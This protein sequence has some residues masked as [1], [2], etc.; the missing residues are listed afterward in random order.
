MNK[1]LNFRAAL[2]GRTSYSIASLHIAQEL[3]LLG[4]DI[5]L[6][7]IGHTSTQKQFVEWISERLY[8]KAYPNPKSPSFVVWHEHSL[9]EHMSRPFYA[10]T[11]FEV[12][13]FHEQTLNSLQFPD[14]ILVCSLWAKEVMRQNHIHKPVTVIPLGVD[15]SIFCPRPKPKNNTYVFLNIGKW[16]VRK[17]HDILPDIFNK[18]FIDKDDVELWMC[19]SSFHYSAKEVKSWKKLYLDSPLGHKIRFFDEQPTQRE[20]ADLIANSDCGIYPTKAEGF[21]LP[22]LETMAMNKPV[23][24]TNYSGQTEFCTEKNSYLVS[25]S[26]MEPA[27]DNKWFFGQGSWAHLSNKVDDFVDYMRLCYRDRP[28]NKEGVIT[29]K[30]FSWQNS[31]EL[32]FK[33]IYGGR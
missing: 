11:I 15:N 27:Q 23:I 30:E 14:Q 28:D 6:F 26:K 7:P 29:G 33:T 4:V 19:P 8:T 9:Y 25:P 31:A 12:D 2:N 3:A 5:S 16:E 17:G 1:G 21:G 20:V 22:I 18:A 13:K 24:T 32:I 10:M